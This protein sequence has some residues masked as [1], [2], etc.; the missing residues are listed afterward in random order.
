MDHALQVGPVLRGHQF[1]PQ[2]ER[3][4]HRRDV[5][6]GHAIEL[7]I[8]VDERIRRPD[9][10]RDAIQAHNPTPYFVS[11]ASVDVSGGGRTARFT[12]GGMVA[13]GETKAFVLQGDVPS[14]ATATITYH[15]IND[16][17][18]P[19]EGEAAL[20]GNPATGPNSR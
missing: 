10:G 4:A 19:T 6:G 20:N 11:L 16:Y 3:L 13:P 9:A 14:A 5:V 12:E 7:A 15:A 8:D 2:P 1:E 17:G 18:G